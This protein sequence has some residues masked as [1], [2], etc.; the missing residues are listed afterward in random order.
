VARPRRLR[1]R[2]IHSE[3]LSDDFPSGAES[4]RHVLSVSSTASGA[5][6]NEVGISEWPADCRRDAEN[7]QKF[8]VM[9]FTGSSTGGSGR[10][11]VYFANVW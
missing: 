8:G 11:T 5:P 4:L 3:E 1:R 7:V 2:A 9:R 10:F 6:N